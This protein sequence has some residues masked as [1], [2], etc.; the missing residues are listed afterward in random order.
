[1]P[2]SHP[3]ARKRFTRMLNLYSG[4]SLTGR[5]WYTPGAKGY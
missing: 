4:L 2:E 3:L 5:A 1:M